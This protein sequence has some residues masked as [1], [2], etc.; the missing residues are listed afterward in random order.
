[1]HFIYMHSKPTLDR[2]KQTLLR[3]KQTLVRA[4]IDNFMN[5]SV[6]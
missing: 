2:A 1:M 3:A 4:Q 6:K 5:F